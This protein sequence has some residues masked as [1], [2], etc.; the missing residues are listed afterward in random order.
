MRGLMKV[1]KGAD[2]VIEASGAGAAISQAVDM[3]RT[4]G[5]ICAIGLGSKDEA[6]FKW[7]SAMYKALTVY[8]NFSS[9]YSFWDKALRLMVSTR[10]DLAKIITHKTSIDNWQQVFQDIQDE[11]GIKGM[12]IPGM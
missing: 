4:T 6:R 12:F 2:L 10:Y 7:N 9:S 5:R 8:F 11:K 3:A 1:A